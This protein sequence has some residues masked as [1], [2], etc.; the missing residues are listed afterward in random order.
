M[1]INKLL[2]FLKFSLQ[3]RQTQR[4]IYAVGDKRMENDVEHSYQLALLTWYVIESEKLK[5][6]PNLAIRYTLVHDLEEAING[7]VDAFN[8]KGRENKEQKEK[9]ARKKIMKMFPNWVSYKKLSKQYKEQ[10]DEESK[11]VN[12]L[13]KILPVINIYLDKGRTWKKEGM[14]LKRITE[15]KRVKT[16]VHPLTH[17]LWIKI[18]KMLIKEES[19]LFLKKDP[20]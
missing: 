14:T 10:N 11:L 4:A 17:D 1:K 9:V 16:A 3:F 12:G 7:D 2:E 19:K 18:E 6:D 15:N 13:D 5:L 8:E 20:I